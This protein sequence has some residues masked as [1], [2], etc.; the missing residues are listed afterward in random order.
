METLDIKFSDVS[1]SCS[2]LRSAARDMM[3]LW[4][5]SNALTDNVAMAWQGEAADIYVQK[6]RD[7]AAEIKKA[8]EALEEMCQQLQSAAQNIQRV[9][10]QIGQNVNK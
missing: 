6:C 2:E 5:K 3:S 9:E 8:G 10:Q 7:L 4:T 1:K